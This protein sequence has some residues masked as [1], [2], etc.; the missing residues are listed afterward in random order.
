MIRQELAT[1]FTFGERQ[2]RLLTRLL[3]AFGLSIVVFV[4]GPC[5]YGYLKAGRRAEA[6][7]DSVMGPFSAL[8]NC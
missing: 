4:A 6:S 3:R 7:A 8:R 1:L 5:S 2:R